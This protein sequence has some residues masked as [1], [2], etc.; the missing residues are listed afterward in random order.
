MESVFNYFVLLGFFF[1]LI[2]SEFCHTLKWNGLEFT[3]LPTQRLNNLG[4]GKQVFRS[5][6]YVCLYDWG[7]DMGGSKSDWDSGEGREGS[8]RRG[9][10]WKKKLLNWILK[11]EQGGSLDGLSPNLL[12][13]RSCNEILRSPVGTPLEVHWLRLCTPNAGY[14]GSI[15]GGEITIS[16]ATPRGQNK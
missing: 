12:P 16:H 10:I 15:P 5:D 14:M 7:A 6:R 1:F 9:S 8:W 13:E 2:C 11:K 3:C 4:P